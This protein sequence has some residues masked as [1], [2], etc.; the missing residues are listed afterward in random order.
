MFKHCGPLA[1]APAFKYRGLAALLAAALLASSLIACGGGSSRNVERVIVF[2][3]SLSD[4]GTY[5]NRA[6]ALGVPQGGKYTVNPGPLWI[7]HVAA[8]YGT[9]I[10]PNRMAGFG[11]APVIQGGTGYAEGGARAAEQPGSGNTDATL[12]ENS[13]ASTLPVKDQ[14]TAHL[15]QKGG[16]NASDLVFVWVGTNDIFRP[17]GVAPVAAEVGLAQVQKA[18]DDLGVQITRMKAGGA[19]KIA[20]LNIDDWGKAPIVA[21]SSAA[22]AYAT[23]LSTAFNARLA[24]NLNG[25]AGVTLVDI[26]ALFAD[27][28]SHPSKYGLTNLTTPACQPRA[29]TSSYSALCTA[30]TL[31]AAGANKN[32][33]YADTVH[34]TDTANRIISDHVLAT[35]APIFPK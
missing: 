14:V 12:G 7:E 31:V 25:M 6:I 24:A 20:V 18:A 30:D 17:V 19:Q 4:L 5:K 26:Q 13:G 23:A 27:L 8:Y 35:V 9:S 15:T 1:S 21:G 28:R 3:D 29:E 11:F 33:L 10:G 16:F 34:Y 32:S 22:Q 2:G